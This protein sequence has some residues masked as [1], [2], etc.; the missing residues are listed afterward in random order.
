MG[1]KA[2]SRFTHDKTAN[3]YLCNSFL[4]KYYSGMVKYRHYSIHA[5][6]TNE[7]AG[8]SSAALAEF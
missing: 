8:R 4:H 6:A 1:L 2:F 5:G 3:F 7:G